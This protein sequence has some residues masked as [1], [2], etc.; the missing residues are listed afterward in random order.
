[1]DK[2]ELREYVQPKEYKTVPSTKIDRMKAMDNIG[3][4]LKEIAEA[5]GLPVTTVSYYVNGGDEK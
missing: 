2:D 3:Y 4:T 5:T 1:M